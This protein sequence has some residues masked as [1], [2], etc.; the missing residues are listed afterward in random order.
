MR[1][2]GEC[3]LCCT[4]LPVEEIEKPA[5]ASCCHLSRLGGCSVYARRPL[6][7]RL[8]SCRWLTDPRTESLPRPDQ[9]HYVV[10]IGTDQIVIGDSD[11]FALEVLQVWVDPK[12]PDAHRC[13]RLRSYLNDLQMPAIVRYSSSEGI[14]I[15][16]PSVT[17]SPEWIERGSNV[18]QTRESFQRTLDDAQRQLLQP[19]EKTT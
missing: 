8:W 9:C 12:Y 6:G 14:V 19:E 13:E 11:K 5:G 17:G 15:F 18:H 2:C 16:P 1:R 4:L 10:D 7:C 3:S